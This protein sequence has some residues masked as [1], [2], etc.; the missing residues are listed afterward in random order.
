[1]LIPIF[2]LALMVVLPIAIGIYVYRDAKSRSMNAGLWTLVAIFAPGFIGLIIYL[3]VRSEHS[4]LHCP[5]CS[6]PVRERFAVCPRCGTPLKDR[7][8][9]CDFPLEQDWSVCPNC[10]EP[11][12]PE[13]RA[14]MSVRAKTDTGIKKLLAI[15]IIA[16][17]LFCILL[18]VGVSAYS[19]GGVSQSVF[20]SITLDDPSLGTQQIRSWLYGCDEAGEGIYVLKAVSKKEGAVETQYLIYRNDGYYD[21]SESIS[22]GGWLSKSRVTIHFSDGE[23]DQDYSL[24]YYKCTGDKEMDIRIRQFNRSVKFQ[25]ETVEAIPLPSSQW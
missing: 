17:T 23:V 22:T 6:A 10:A 1:M 8:Q 25:M 12:P 18:V 24:Y 11:I 13:Q 16:P 20:A 7:C 15:V 21:V 5:Q 19:A 3:V 4:A 14:N 9:H 2:L